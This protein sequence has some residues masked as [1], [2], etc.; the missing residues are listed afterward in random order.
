VRRWLLSYAILAPRLHNLQSR[1]VD[2][3]VPPE[4]LLSCDLKR[5]PPQA[6][7]EYAEQAK[8]YRE[9]HGLAGATGPAPAAAG[10]HPGVRPF[11]AWFKCQIGLWPSYILRK[12]LLNR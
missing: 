10:F 9:I 7:Q 8:P 2:L 11:A 3:S 5:P 4:I 1:V 6:L 12:Q